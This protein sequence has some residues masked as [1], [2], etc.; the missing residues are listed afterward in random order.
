MIPDTTGDRPPVF[1]WR[2][3]QPV[4]WYHRRP[5]RSN[6][7]CL[8]CSRFVG[9]GSTIESD[10]EHL[11]GKNFV[12]TGTLRGDSFNFHFRACCR[13]NREKSAAE[14][15]VSSVTLFTSPARAED[16]AVNALAERKA[17]RS[18]HP[19]QRG[20]NGERVPVQ[21]AY[22]E[23]TLRGEW[24]PGSG[25]GV[26]VSFVGPPQLHHP[27]VHLLVRCHVQ[28]FFS[29][30]TSRDPTRPETTHLL[31]PEECFIYREYAH[32]DWGNAE[33]CELT[34]RT[35][36]WPCLG[37]IYTADGYFRAKFKR[38]GGPGTEWFWALEWNKTVRVVGSHW[39]PGAVP[40][41][42]EDLVA[43]RRARTR[44]TGQHMMEET[45]LAPEEDTLFR[46]EDIATW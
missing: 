7:Q 17:A 14:D 2:D 9:P 37:Q 5:E 24:M 41:L 6:Q 21:D 25:I 43:A 29:L 3:R 11:I 27:L 13:C 20:P 39:V 4:V 15:H 26:T 30:I 16:A 42:F 44:R 1:R 45:P 18:I 23:T 38:A 19:T 22:V 34:R 40:P 28:G 31:L 10:C 12:P 36:G 35:A 8:Y 32:S 46:D 33:L